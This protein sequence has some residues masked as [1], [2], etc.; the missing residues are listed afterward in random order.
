[1]F[2]FFKAMLLMPKPWVAWVG[3]LIAVNMVVPFFFM[4]R[5]EAK[6]VLATMMASA[7]LMMFIFAQKRF[8][9]PLGVRS[10]LMDSADPLVVG[11]GESGSPGHRV[12][13]MDS[14]GHRFKRLVIGD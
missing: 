14:D 7:A 5:L 2:N 8:R 13:S 9:P 3:L 1:M 11:K 4:A 10:Y 12:R 6:V